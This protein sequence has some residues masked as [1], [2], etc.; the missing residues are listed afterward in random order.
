MR[1]LVMK[2]F[3]TEEYKDV[4]VYTRTFGYYFE[5]LFVFKGEI[6]TSFHRVRPDFWHGML[7]FLRLKPTPYSD[8]QINKSRAAV[9]EIAKQVIDHLYFQ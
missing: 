2:N 4:K 3:K 7:Y 8:E 5:L 9:L 1:E 6:H